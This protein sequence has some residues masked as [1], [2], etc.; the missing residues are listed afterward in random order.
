[1]TKTHK[2]G[3]VALKRV[4]LKIQDGEFVF[5]N[6]HSGAGKSTIVR[7]LMCEDVPTYG[8]VII[9]GVN[10]QDLSHRQ[11]PKFRRQMGVVFQDFRLNP[12]MNV[13]DNIAF[14]MRV[15]GRKRKEI[16]Q[17]VATV[18]DIVGLSHKT[19]SYP[20]QLSGGEQQRVAIARAIVNSPKMIIADEPTGNIDPKMSLEVMEM[21]DI[22]NKSGI[23]VVVVTHEKDLVERFGKR[24]ITLEKGRIKFDTAHPEIVRNPNDADDDFNEDE[25]RALELEHSRRVN[26]EKRVHFGRRHR[27]SLFETDLDE[28]EVD[29]SRGIFDDEPDE[30]SQPEEDDE[31]TSILQ[32]ETVLEQRVE[33]P[34]VP[35]EPVV[36]ADSA[37]ESVDVEKLS[38]AEVVEPE[39]AT[40]TEQSQLTE[41]PLSEE[42]PAEKT[43]PAPQEDPNKDIEDFE[44]AKM[45]LE[46]S[47]EQIK[48]D[49]LSALSPDKEPSDT[50]KEEAEDQ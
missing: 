47:F 41:T 4:S 32:S 12:S 20:S 17:R 50:E 30:S 6:G 45:D 18:L 2:N 35:E 15:V 23:T 3:T 7:L 46:K 40:D 39:D 33:A 21:L 24:V 49:I 8:D 42:T 28:E 44:R 9:D 43:E 14:A 13:Y 19:K 36:A 16:K 26:R 22:I 38:T 10:T 11:I 48:S 5:I 1:M 31:E 25:I 37:V 29:L 27:K 34:S